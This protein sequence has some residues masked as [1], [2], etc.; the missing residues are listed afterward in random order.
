MST[1][2]ATPR[3]R[4]SALGV[5]GLV[6]GAGLALIACAAESSDP[7]G[8]QLQVVTSFYPLQF[9]TQ[10][11][12]G[13]AVSATNATKAGVEPHDLELSAQDTAQLA[14][15]DLTVFLSGFQPAID[16]AVESLGAEALDVASA[17]D[18]NLQ[19][20]PIADGEEESDEAG[21][22]PHFWLDPLR[23]ADV[24]DAV[25]ARL[26]ELVPADRATFE[27]NAQQ[28]RT[29]LEALS[30]EYATALKE[31]DRRELVTSHNAFGYL[32]QA[33]DLQQVGITGLTPE[34]EPSPQQLAAVADFVSENNVSTIFYETLVSPDV[35]ETLAGSTGARTAVLDPLEGLDDDAA[36]DYF[37]VMRANLDA[38][39]VGLSCG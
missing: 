19:Y 10:Q 2:G 39:T 28:L 17:A 15:A 38:L 37:D 18:L 16:D 13:D 8:E 31:C 1:T 4:S 5:V 20:T 32:A 26:S 14:D 23:L 36:G 24:G 29:Q 35:A 7:G 12:G 3:R 22:D 6:L 27:A 34:S 30:D 25:A 33:F 21:T 11:I 9:V